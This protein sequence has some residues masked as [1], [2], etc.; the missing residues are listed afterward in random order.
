MI[1][2][3]IL[4]INVTKEQITNLKKLQKGLLVPVYFEKKNIYF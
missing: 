1:R 4:S 3:G 2:R